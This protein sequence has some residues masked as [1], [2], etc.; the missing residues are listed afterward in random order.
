VVPVEDSPPNNGRGCPTSPDFLWSFVGSLNFM[1]LSLMKGAH[2]VLSRA[3]YRKFGA[4][5]L[6]FASPDYSR[7]GKGLTAPARERGF[8]HT[9]MASS[10]IGFAVKNFRV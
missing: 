2:A 8:T 4:F 5:R 9:G 10:G 7:T 6:F 1:R 3:A